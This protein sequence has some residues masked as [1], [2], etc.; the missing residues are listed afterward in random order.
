MIAD[1]AAMASLHGRIGDEEEVVSAWGLPGNGG[2]FGP[3]QLND[4]CRLQHE[5]PAKIHRVTCPREDQD[6]PRHDPLGG[7]SSQSRAPFAFVYFLPKQ[8]LLF[9]PLHRQLKLRPTRYRT[10]R[11]K[12]PQIVPSPDE[13]TF[14]LASTFI[15]HHISILQQ[16]LA[17]HVP[18]HGSVECPQAERGTSWSPFRIPPRIRGGDRRIPPRVAVA[19]L[20]CATAHLDVGSTQSELCHPPA[21]LHDEATEQHDDVGQLFEQPRPLHVGI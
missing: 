15:H 19:D 6:P 21:R 9:C 10:I 4:G 7:L 11:R 3:R 17:H 16:K 12:P 14:T 2:R 18:R 5:S 8:H 13:P 1:F 20:A